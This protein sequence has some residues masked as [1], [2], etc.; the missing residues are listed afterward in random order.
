MVVRLDV[1]ASASDAT[2][3]PG[4]RS[5]QARWRVDRAIDP[6]RRPPRH[7]APRARC[8]ASIPLAPSGHSGTRRSRSALAMTD[9]ELNVMA[10]LATTGLSSRPRAGY[11]TPA[12]IGTPSML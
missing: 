5:P 1:G 6:G 2:P 3:S 10:A 11:N 12:A 4:R 7:K 8:P 9:T